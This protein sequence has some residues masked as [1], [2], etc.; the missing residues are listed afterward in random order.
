MRKK[1]IEHCINTSVE[2]FLSDLGDEPPHSL[3]D[4]FI[5][6]VEKPLLSTVMK[7][8]KQNQSTAAQWLGI[9]RN[10]L[11]KKLLEHDLIAK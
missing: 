8:A 10:T 4:I 2:K 11:R 5:S 6:S 3:Y 7:H 1:D 9:N